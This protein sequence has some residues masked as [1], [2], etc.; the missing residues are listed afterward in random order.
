LNLL[1]L[2]QA[3]FPAHL[4]IRDDSVALIIL[5]NEYKL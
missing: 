2:V 3:M 5:G 1:S 4:I